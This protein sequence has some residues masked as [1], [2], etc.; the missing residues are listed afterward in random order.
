[1]LNEIIW[2]LEDL[3]V[4]N[5]KAGINVLAAVTF[6]NCLLFI[7]V[8]YGLFLFARIIPREKNLDMRLKKEACI[9]KGPVHLIL[10]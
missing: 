9:I 10:I 5:P 8:M 1:M 2:V 4:L 3:D 7:N 6:T